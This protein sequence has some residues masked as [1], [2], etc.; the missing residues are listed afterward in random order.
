METSRRDLLNYMVE[1]GSIMKNNQ[2]KL[3]SFIFLDRPTFSRINEKL[4][5]RAVY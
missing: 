5:A 4:S 3:Y 1:H 2:N